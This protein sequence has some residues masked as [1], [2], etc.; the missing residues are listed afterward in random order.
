[1][2]IKNVMVSGR[3]RIQPGPTK[4]PVATVLIRT[5]TL[6]VGQDII[7]GGTFGRI[8]RIEDFA[9]RNLT[10]ALP[11]VPATILASMNPQ[12]ST[13]LFRSSVAKPLPVSNHKNKANTAHSKKYALKKMR[14]SSS[15]GVI[16]KADVQGSVEALQQIL[17]GIGNEEIILEEISCRRRCHHRKRCQASRKRQSHDTRIQCRTNRR[18]QTHGRKRPC[19]S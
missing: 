7:A 10:A 17:S 14:M 11:S 5:G 18:R 9:G 1:V 13:T 8:R 6:K 16:I 12:P 15:F 19:Q 3:S 2:P 4:G